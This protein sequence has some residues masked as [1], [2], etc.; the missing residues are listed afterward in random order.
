MAS[1]HT[2]S[3]IFA[4]TCIGPGRGRRSGGLWHCGTAMPGCRLAERLGWAAFAELWRLCA[5]RAVRPICGE[6]GR[7]QLQGY[8]LARG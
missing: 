8:M 3:G 2:L 1:W 7:F 4:R 5:A 6:A